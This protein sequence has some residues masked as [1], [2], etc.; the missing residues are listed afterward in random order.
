[1]SGRRGRDFTRQTLTRRQ[2]THYHDRHRKKVGPLL[3][4]LSHRP[5][6]VRAGGTA[7]S[8]GYRTGRD[9][10]PALSS[11]RIGDVPVVFL[12]P[13][14]VHLHD[15]IVCYVLGGHDC[16]NLAVI[17]AVVKLGLSQSCSG[18]VAIAVQEGSVR[19]S[20]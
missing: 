6:R 19:L 12:T 16:R 1:M 3:G 13:D 18:L 10:L 8:A 11:C 7:C 17:S 15:D 14:V 5:I 2:T 4:E 9:A 20:P